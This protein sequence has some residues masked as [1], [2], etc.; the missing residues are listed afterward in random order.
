M[1]IFLYEISK[2]F[3][4]FRKVFN[5]I[6]IKFAKSEKSF[7]KAEKNFIGPRWLYYELLVYLFE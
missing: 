2:S 1:D 3:D 4:K 6:I 7:N 5:K